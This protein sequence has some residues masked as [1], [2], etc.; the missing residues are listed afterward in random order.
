MPGL[1]VVIPAFNEALR[2]PRTLTEILGILAPS[3]RDFEILVVDDGSLDGTSDVAREFAH[4]DPRLR[5]IRVDRN[6]GKGHAVKV[7]VAQAT[8]ETVLYLD[9]DGSTP[10]GE[11]VKLERALVAGADVVIGTREA[12][13][14]AQHVKARWHR[15]ALRAI[16]NGIVALLVVRGHTDTQC[17]FKL[18]RAPA[19]AAIFPR[20]RLDG[21]GF[22]VELLA[23]ARLDGLKVCE[24]AIDWADQPGSK[25]NLVVDGLRMLR[26]LVK[27]RLGML[28]GAYSREGEVEAR[29]PAAGQESGSPRP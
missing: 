19:A 27:I 10:F 28:A 2:L 29:I 11:L 12:K 24:V 9:A 1:S 7:G 14:E 20:V 17:G 25:I 8:G 22:D 13:R 18:L 6:R 16:F 3:G 5:L 4:I 23:I 21:Y 26:D 15:R